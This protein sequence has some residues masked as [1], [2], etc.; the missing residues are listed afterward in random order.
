MSILTIIDNPNFESSANIDAT[1][2]WQRNW[3]EYKKVIYKTVSL[4]QK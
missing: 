3:D 2:L 4:T 1:N